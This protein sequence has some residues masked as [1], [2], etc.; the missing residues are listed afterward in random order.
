MLDLQKVLCSLGSKAGS[1]VTYFS[2]KEFQAFEAAIV[3]HI[4]CSWLALS[5]KV[6]SKEQIA[7]L[8]KVLEQFFRKAN[9]ISFKQHA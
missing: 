7:E 9:H 2:Q 4:N 8:E 3:G 1:Q 5:G 6:L